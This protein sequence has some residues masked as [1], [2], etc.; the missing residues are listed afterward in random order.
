MLT[1]SDY[2][3][4]TIYLI[5][6]AASFKASEAVIPGLSFLRFMLCFGLGAEVGVEILQLAGKD[7]N[8]PYYVYIPVE[9]Y[10]LTRF[11]KRNTDVAAIKKA[12]DVSVPLYVV[13]AAVLSFFHYR[14]SGYPSVIYNISCFFN[15]IWIA[16]LLFNFNRDNGREIWTHPLFVI[17]SALL[18]FFA[19]TFFFNPA[20]SF[21]QKK[22]AV[23]AKHLRTYINTSLNYIL[24]TLLSYGFICSAKT[25]K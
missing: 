12:L 15:T 11:Y 14:F 25:T 8:P 6:L 17:L 22:D 7:Y 10:C 2:I 3:Y 5:C 19:G 24:Y 23:L 18:I 4:Y 9:Y 21:I 1:T 20:Y 16:L 13:V